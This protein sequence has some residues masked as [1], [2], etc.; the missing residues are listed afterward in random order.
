[1]RLIDA[2]PLL[3]KTDINRSSYIPVIS[4]YD[5]ITQPTVRAVPLAELKNLRNEMNKVL[6][7]TTT[8]DNIKWSYMTM[9]DDL[10]EEYDGD[11][12]EN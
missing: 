3:E 10:I 4:R 2:D 5:I 1:M 8:E 6:T 9:I 7:I 11:K 12:R